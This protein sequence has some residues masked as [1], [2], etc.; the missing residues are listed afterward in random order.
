M[1]RKNES[2]CLEQKKRASIDGTNGSQGLKGDKGA[3]GANGAN[4]ANGAGFNTATLAY[5]TTLQTFLKLNSAAKTATL[6]G[7]N[8]QAIRWFNV[9]YASSCLYLSRYRSLYMGSCIH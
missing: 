4:G 8:L 6:S 5:V 1:E 2:T 7:V 3:K 9:L